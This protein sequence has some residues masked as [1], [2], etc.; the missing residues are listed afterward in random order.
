MRLLLTEVASRLPHFPT[1]AVRSEGPSCE[2]VTSARSRVK[3]VESLAGGNVK[4]GTR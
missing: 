1:F 3:W 4:S 2:K